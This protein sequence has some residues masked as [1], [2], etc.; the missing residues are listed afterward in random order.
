[1]GVVYYANYLVWMEVGRVELCK[2][3]GFDYKDMEKED[4]AML[5][6]AEAHCRYAYPARFD[7]EVI[8][9]TWVAAAS[10]RMVTFGYEMKVAEGNRKVAAGE[11]KHVF[12][13][14]DL[15]PRRMPEKYRANFGLTPGEAPEPAA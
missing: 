6:V 2:A 5:A 15:K 12:V 3:S 11:T 1:M 14:R 10:S 7:D 8:V 4:G 9:T 13:G